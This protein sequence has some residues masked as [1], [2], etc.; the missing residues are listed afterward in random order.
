[1]LIRLLFQYI[2]PL[3]ALIFKYM[4]AHNTINYSG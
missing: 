2:V 3:L 4:Y 1:M